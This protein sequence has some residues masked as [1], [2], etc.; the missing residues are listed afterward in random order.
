[1]SNAKATATIL[2]IAS[3]DGNSGS[4]AGVCRLAS[5]AAEP[6]SWAPPFHRVEV[7]DA[8][9][10]LTCYGWPGEFTIDG[11]PEQFDIVEVSG[12]TRIFNGKAIADL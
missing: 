7:V 10:T 5:L 1:M 3:L 6:R 2:P 9:G 4:F 11:Q 12:A 8:S